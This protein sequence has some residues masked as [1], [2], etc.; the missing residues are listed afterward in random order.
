MMPRGTCP[1]PQPRCR[2]NYPD[3]GRGDLCR[4]GS[5]HRQQD[6]ANTPPPVY[7]RRYYKRS[8]FCG[9]TAARQIGNR[10]VSGFEEMRLTEHSAIVA[11]KPY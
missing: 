1:L 5:L 11:T 9:S 3:Q 4:E 8:Q 10:N 6:P 2:T 7:R